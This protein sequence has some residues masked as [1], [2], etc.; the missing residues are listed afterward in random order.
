M[1]TADV[2]SIYGIYVTYYGRAADRG[3]LE[4]WVDQGVNKKVSLESIA[5]GFAGAQESKDRYP[6]LAFPNTSDPTEFVKSIYRNAFGR[7]AEAAGLAFWVNE[8]KTKGS[9]QAPTFILTVLIN[10]QGTD[11]TALQNKATGAKRFTD[12][13]IN[14]NISPTAS[15]FTDSTN[16]LN[17]IKETPESVTA[18][19]TSIDAKINDYKSAGTAGTT[20]ALTTSIVD[21]LVGTGN[22]DT[23]IGANAVPSGATDTVQA[24]DKI[25]G[26]A[27]IDTFQYSGASA[28]AIVPTL[29]NVEKV[30]LLNPATGTTIDFTGKATGLQ[31]VIIKPPSGTLAAFTANGLSGIT[32]GVEGATLT[33]GAVPTTTLTTLTANFGSTTTSATLSIK[34]A[35]V[36]TATLSGNTALT[37]LNLV[38][39]GLG[40]NSIGTLTLPTATTTLNI[41]GAGGVEVTNALPTTVATIN[42]SQNTG[43]VKVAV[44][45]V[46]ATFT[47]GSG[48]DTFSS[49]LATFDANDKLDGGAGTTDTLT[50][51]GTTATA[52][53]TLELASINAVRN[54]EVLSLEGAAATVD[55]TQVT[56]FK[57]YLFK[58]TAAGNITVTGATAS[59]TFALAGTQATPAGNTVTT[60]ALTGTGAANIALQESATITTLNLT[61]ITTL[62][63]DSK[64]K[65]SATTNT[66]TT[67]G[68]AVP[69]KVK[70]DGNLTIATTV[71][72]IV[73]NI[74]ATGFKGN[75]TATG[76]TGND[77]LIGGDLNDTLTGS[78]GTDRLVGG[79]GRDTLTGTGTDTFVFAI[80]GSN[81][82][83]FAG[84]TTD[85]F[86]T[87]TGSSFT[88]ASDKIELVGTAFNVTSLTSQS[89]VQAAVGSAS[90]LSAALASAA[91]AIGASKFGAFTFGADTY[92]LGNDA[93]VGTLNQN[94]LLIKLNGN[95]TLA[96]ADFTFA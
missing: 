63:I 50:L 62:N 49:T 76:G 21:N 58:L 6:Y 47:G 12:G 64:K 32:L 95:L 61:G 35:I 89:A 59:N 90:T 44:G 83:N 5:A 57:D 65:D 53:T 25:D 92:V 31:Q 22:N 28:T 11:R 91:T 13:L 2:N 17:T 43:G 37:T 94:D 75:L 24:S 79:L 42:A 73:R 85:T 33:A 70:G 14:N 68:N 15:I 54:F 60:F 72:A 8:L 26:G 7:E 56:A 40:K 41:S 69:I 66:I 39:D 86:D 67:L 84:G 77:I 10:A 78:A 74:D 18:G 4:F 48:N 80:A 3:G 23:F 93:T 87:I 36:T 38:A 88:T 27:G 19:N 30:E 16:I 81:A 71:S 55:A 51:T 46:N 82:G 9:G 96:S 45:T 1:T 34:D 29:L 20:I 52:L